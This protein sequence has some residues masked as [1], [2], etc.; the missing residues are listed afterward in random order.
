MILKV[1]EK[2]SEAVKALCDIALKAGGLQSLSAINEI[3][4]STVLLEPEP[5]E[6]T[7]VKSS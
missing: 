5:V 4:R 3:M 7:D 2:G 6:L 1:D